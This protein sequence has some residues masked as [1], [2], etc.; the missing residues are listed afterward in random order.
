[1][2]ISYWKFE[3]FQEIIDIRQS[4][5]IHHTVIY[6]PVVLLLY[7][8]YDFSFPLTLKW[9]KTIQGIFWYFSI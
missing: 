9:S 7:L 3:S 8:S 6:Y 4:Y 1:M 2:Q 5:V